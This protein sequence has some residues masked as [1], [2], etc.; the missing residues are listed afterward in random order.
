[1]R[2]V[3]DD[4]SD[5]GAGTGYRLLAF[6]VPALGIEIVSTSHVGERMAVSSDASSSVTTFTLGE[7][8][9]SVEE[10]EL[11][12]EAYKKQAFV[13]FYRRDSRTRSGPTSE[14]RAE[15]L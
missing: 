10:F 6:G 15:I 12:L 9:N 5:N 1:M 2:P 8:F 14:G 11:K 4:A 7:K 3:L 13:E